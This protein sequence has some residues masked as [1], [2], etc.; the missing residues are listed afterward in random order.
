[1]ASVWSIVELGVITGLTLLGKSCL[2]SVLLAI[3]M[4]WRFVTVAEPLAE[5]LAPGVRQ[6]LVAGSRFHT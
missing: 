4:S 1:M 6:A 3:A 2:G 5:R